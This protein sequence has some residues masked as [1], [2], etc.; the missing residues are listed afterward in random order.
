M[1]AIWVPCGCHS[2]LGWLETLGGGEVETGFS[3]VV[4]EGLTLTDSSTFLQP[5][6]SAWPDT[7]CSAAFFLPQ[8]VW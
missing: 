3:L 8:P 2:G 5:L 6:A 7:S 4:G 1:C